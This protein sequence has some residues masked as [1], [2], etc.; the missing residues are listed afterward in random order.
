MITRYC[1]HVSHDSRV[2]AR[3]PIFVV[4]ILVKLSDV[5]VQA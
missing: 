3:T 1:N 2:N 4:Q 5:V